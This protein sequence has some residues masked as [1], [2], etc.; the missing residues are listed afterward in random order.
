VTDHYLEHL[1]VCFDI[2]TRILESV[3]VVVND[4]GVMRLIRKHYSRITPILGR[5]LNRSHNDFRQ[6]NAANLKYFPF[7]RFLWNYGVRRVEFDCPIQTTGINLEKAA[8]GASLYFPFDCCAINRDGS[9]R[10]NDETDWQKDS[11]CRE[12]IRECGYS[13]EIPSQ[14]V[15]SGMSSRQPAQVTGSA[16]SCEGMTMVTDLSF[17]KATR[18][19]ID[20]LVFLAGSTV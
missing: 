18:S 10:E 7:R 4:W 20:R 1:K 14:N 8:L 17:Q 9:R 11:R 15:Q 19:I 2:L 5:V 12:C 16:P 6:S 13:C 3:E